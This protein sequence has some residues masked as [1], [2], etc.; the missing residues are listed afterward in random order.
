MT[1]DPNAHDRFVLR[2]RIRLIIN[3]YEFALSDDH[4][5]FCFVEQ[6]RFKFK[7]DIRFY[8]DAA[9]SEELMRIKARQ[10]FDPWATYDVTAADGTK[11]GELQKAFGQSLLRSTF[12]IH[13]PT[14]TVSAHELSLAVALFRRAVGFVPLIGDVADWLP[15]PY[16]FVFE[17]DGQPLGVH[18]RRFGRFRDVYDIDMSQDSART[19][20]RRLVLA[21]AVG[22]DALQAR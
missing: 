14:G 2:Q 11:L 22:M 13:T 9:K 4:A 19:L 16:H 18:K 10:A 1:V 5:P 15:I 3:Q 7:E 20:D 6:A 8:T 21:A 12:L 17:R